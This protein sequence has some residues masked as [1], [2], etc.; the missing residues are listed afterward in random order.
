M[1][2]KLITGTVAFTLALAGIALADD[3]MPPDWRG[4]PLTVLAEWEFTVDFT[5]DPLNVPPENLITAG[6]GTHLLGDAWTHAHV[7]ENVF[8]EVDPG[9]PNDG[10]AYTLDLPGQIDFFLVNWID[11]Y[12]FKHIWIQIT[13]GGQGRPVVSGVLGPNPFDNGW[14]DPT[15]G[16]FQFAIEVDPNHRVESWILMP[17]PDREHVYV[18]VPPW[19]WVDQVVIDTISTPEPVAVE[20]RNWSDVK[21][22]FD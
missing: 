8:W 12:E 7:G 6:D 21:A 4:D 20:S 14:V 11:E 13:Y 9:D 10:R 2:T 5:P 18:D 22:L 3:F 19:T 15:F 16:V 1:Q 17:N